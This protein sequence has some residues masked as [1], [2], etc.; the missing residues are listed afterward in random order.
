[1]EGIL[2]IH[3]RGRV[4][5][6]DPC[7]PRAWTGFEFTY[8][9]GSSRYRITV[10]NPNGVSRGVVSATLDGREIPSTPCEITLIDDGNYHY[11][12]VTLG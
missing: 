5:A 4:L 9:C 8:K 10:E 3:L 11:G 1:V 2:G 7:V 6:I 12:L